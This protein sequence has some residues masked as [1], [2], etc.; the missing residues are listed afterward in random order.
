MAINERSFRAPFH[1]YKAKWPFCQV[2]L[3][4]ANF[5]FGGKDFPF[6]KYQKKFWREKN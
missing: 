1:I 5:F 2:D 4:P 6:P 3:F